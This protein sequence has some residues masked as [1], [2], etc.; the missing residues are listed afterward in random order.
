M[1]GSHSSVERD[2]SLLVCYIEL[3]GKKIVMCQSSMQ[4]T[5]KGRCVSVHLTKAYGELEE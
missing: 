5:S 3:I 2:S 1:C 4:P